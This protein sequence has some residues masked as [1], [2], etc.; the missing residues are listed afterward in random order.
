ML[1]KKI[2]AVALSVYAFLSSPTSGATYYYKS[3]VTQNFHCPSAQPCEI[4][5]DLSDHK[6]VYNIYCEDATECTLRC[7]EKKCFSKANIYGGTTPN[8]IV[9]LG[10]KGQ[11][12]F[13]DAK[14]YAPNGGSAYFYNGVA[15][16]GYKKINIFS[17][18]TQEIVLNCDGT[19]G[20]DECKQMNIDASS[21]Q[22]FQLNFNGATEAEFEAGTIKCPVDSSYKGPEIAPCIIDA[23]NGALL[24]VTIDAPDGT[25]KGV[26]IPSCSNCID[27]SVTI[28]CSTVDTL[29]AAQEGSS[30]WPFDQSSDCWWTNHPTSDPTID[31]T[32]D[33]TTD[34]TTDPSNAPSMAPTHAPSNAPS[35]APSDAP[36]HAPSNAPSSPPTRV[37][38]S[39]P[40]SPP[41]SVPSAAPTH[42]PS[43]TP[44]LP[45][46]DAPSA[47]PSQPPS[48]APSQPPTAAPTF[49]PHPT[50]S[51]S[52]TPSTK[53]PSNVPSVYPTRTPSITPSYD[54][55]MS[56]SHIPTP[57]SESPTTFPT[58]F[59]DTR[60]PSKTPTT[61]PTLQPST[62]PTQY[63]SHQPSLSPTSIPS[64]TPTR[65]PTMEP[66]MSPTQYPSYNPSVS[67]SA[68]PSET[69]TSYPSVSPSVYPTLYPSTQP[70]VSPT[71]IPSIPPTDIPTMAPSDDPTMRPS[72]IP[73]SASEMPTTTPTQVTSTPTKYPSFSP[74]FPTLN[75]SEIPTFAPVTSDPSI[76]P[77][78][79]P[80][81]IRTTSDNRINKDSIIQMIA[82]NGDPLWTLIVIIGGAVLVIICIGAAISVYIRKTVERKVEL[83]LRVSSV[84]KGDHIIDIKS[85]S[86]NR[87]MR[88]YADKT[89][90]IQSVAS[91][92]ANV[93]PPSGVIPC[94]EEDV[95]RGHQVVLSQSV[96]SPVSPVSVQ[97]VSS[98]VGLDAPEDTDENDEDI[99]PEEEEASVKAASNTDDFILNYLC[100]FD[101]PGDEDD[102][103]DGIKLYDSGIGAVFDDVKDAEEAKPKPQ[104]VQSRW[105]MM[106][107]FKEA[108][109]R[110]SEYEHKPYKSTG[111][112]AI[113]NNVVRR[114][115]NKFNQELVQDDSGKEDNGSD[116]G[117]MER[118]LGQINENEADNYNPDELNQRKPRLRDDETDDYFEHQQRDSIDISEIGNDESMVVS[119]SKDTNPMDV[120]MPAK[121]GIVRQSTESFHNRLSNQVIGSSYIMDCVLNEIGT[122]D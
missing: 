69:P 35:S 75:P 9:T 110:G 50:V 20:N 107:E 117:S 102:P 71:A 112:N 88:A 16:K 6:Q 106:D 100:A 56:P 45:P 33:P 3:T 63:P 31:P 92:S 39:A 49:P 98:K 61:D 12:C 36:T 105:V 2:T 111:I 72:H 121:L 14:V 28:S 87:K 62:Y 21:A 70:S 90:R 119:L 25:P 29:N 74:S 83:A 93:N 97:R 59:G 1:Y 23:S 19:A 4:V 57:P 78:Q 42:T 116:D 10:K 64:Q 7:E 54:P 60:Y 65:F 113:K 26:W 22:F 41:T 89:H 34:P 79:T 82:G 85:R 5:C 58:K 81:I 91:M 17:D 96:H 24:D 43:R 84:L 46:S 77:S 27:A 18:N 99:E 15:P 13:S 32:V 55:T 11:E 68:I 122:E 67:P 37:P 47:E 66:T 53:A 109:R 86:S 118:Q 48:R 30:A 76:S 114:M 52:Q 40:S 8:L 108:V 38:S 94:D 120:R 73:T 44:S 103:F 80:S 115:S 101:T 104:P 95:A 51:P